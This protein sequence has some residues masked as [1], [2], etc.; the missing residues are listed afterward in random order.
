M[1][2]DRIPLSR[3]SFR[4]EDFETVTAVLQ[5]GNLVQGLEVARMEAF[6]ANN[7][8][9]NYAIEIPDLRVNGTIRAPNQVAK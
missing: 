5:S 6:L 2:H 7:R 3:P 8:G 9:L 1:N 4:T